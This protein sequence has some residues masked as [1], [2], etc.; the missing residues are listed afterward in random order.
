MFRHEPV[1]TLLIEDRGTAAWSIP[2]LLSHGQSAWVR[3]TQADDLQTGLSRFSTTSFDIVLLTV[4]SASHA[5]AAIDQV[6][7]IRATCP[8]IIMGELDD[9]ALA[10]SVIERGAADYLV[11]GQCDGAGLARAIH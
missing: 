6:R 3:L 8:V 1:S 11:H 4:A 7:A 10:T 5:L 2:A 9:A